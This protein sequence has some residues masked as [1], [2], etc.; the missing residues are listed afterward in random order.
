LGQ[1]LRSRQVPVK[2]QI[3]ITRSNARV[4]YGVVGFYINSC[5][6]IANSFIKFI[7]TCELVVEKT[8]V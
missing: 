2:P 4:G 6:K 5:L 3:K 1:T 7:K 8:P